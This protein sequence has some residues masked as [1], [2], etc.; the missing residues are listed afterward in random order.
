MEFDVGKCVC[1]RAAYYSELSD[2]PAGKH[3]TLWQDVN[4]LGL[5]RS[6]P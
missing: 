3:I 2:M 1:S 6:F 4:L 5:Y